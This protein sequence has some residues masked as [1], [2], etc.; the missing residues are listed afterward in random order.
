MKIPGGYILQPRCIDNSF[1]AGAPPHVR[2]IWSY[3]LRKANHQPRKAS[4]KLLDRGQLWTSYAQIISDL[5]WKVGYRKESYK[6][7]HIETAMKLLTAHTMITTTKTTRGM[8][9]TV[10]KYDYYQSPK[11]Y[12]TDS[13]TDNET[14]NEP[15]GINKKV[16]NDKKDNAQNDVFR[17]S[18]FLKFWDMY[19]K[20]KDRLKCE[21]KFSKLT[22]AQ[23]EKIFQT[24]PA[25]V[26]STPDPQ[27]RKNPLTYLNAQSWEDEV[28]DPTP[29]TN[30]NTLNLQEY[31]GT[32]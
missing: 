27:Y 6:R 25:Y 12:E 1:I 18:D 19:E 22:K 11:N 17:D 3:L 31:Y 2:E 20:K 8:I 5:S 21:K 24:L 4:G 29:A 30:N 16:K 13:E 28:E 26:A 10:C 23:K 7:H 32:K 15:T 9:V 14:D